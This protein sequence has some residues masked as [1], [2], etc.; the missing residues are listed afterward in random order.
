MRQQRQQ[1]EPQERAARRE[2]LRERWQ[3]MSPEERAAIRKRLGE[4]AQNIP[5]E[6]RAA[7]RRE[8]RERW[9]NMSPEERQRLRRDLSTPDA[10]D[11]YYHPVQIIIIALCPCFKG[12]ASCNEPCSNRN[13]IVSRSR[14]PNCTTKARARST[15]LLLEAA[16]IREYQQIE[17]YN[18][19]NGERFTT[20]AIRG[21]ARLAA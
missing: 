3:Q 1:A 12:G 8:L 5:H 11:L 17:I 14:T 16:D 6:E 21:A 20:Y 10:P 13:C 7:K 19:T 2:A 15:R 9:Q 18:I 4:R